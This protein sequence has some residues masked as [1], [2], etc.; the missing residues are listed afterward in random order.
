MRAACRDLP[1]TSAKP[2][3]AA[4]QRFCIVVIFGVAFAYIEAAVVVYLRTIFHP[5][6]FS[7]PLVNFGAGPLWRRLLLTEVGREAAT[8]VIIATSS[9]LFARGRQERSAY[10]MT[11]FAVWDIF[12][13]VWLKVLIDWPDS[14][15]DWDILFL[16]PVS[17][18]SPVLAPV[19]VSAA[20]LVFAV[21]VLY[22]GSAGRPI[23][24]TLTDKFG[25]FLSAVVVV[26]SFCI[27]GLHITE[28]DY[29]S[30]FYWPLFGLGYA[31]G[32]GLYLKCV[33]QSGRV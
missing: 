10:F 21:V 31:G 6:G 26:V 25:F 11:I 18:A 16:I 15:M 27:G 7:F 32:I 5:E 29:Q 22:R 12:Y 14:I 19:I 8:L 9:W 3:K 17:W 20:L 33:L 24:V 1:E 2:F 28:P 4:L 13:Y 23:K 30:Y